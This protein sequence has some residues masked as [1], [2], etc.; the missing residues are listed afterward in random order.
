[1]YHMVKSEGIKL[2]ITLSTDPV[3]IYP[4]A[5]DLSQLRLRYLNYTNTTQTYVYK[6]KTQ[7]LH[8]FLAVYYFILPLL[9][10]LTRVCHNQGT[11]P[12]LLSYLRIQCN[13]WQYCVIR[14]YVFMWTSGMHR[15]VWLRCRVH[16]TR[17]ALG[18]VITQIGTYQAST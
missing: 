14:C 17:Y 12:C 6:K 15:S 5:E 8:W 10:V 16:T 4:W 1:M 3:S 13:G 7:Q 9:H 18:N 11:L 2:R